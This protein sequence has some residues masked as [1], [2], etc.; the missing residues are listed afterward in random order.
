MVSSVDATRSLRSLSAT[1]QNRALLPVPITAAAQ[2][3]QY[4]L[5][6]WVNTKHSHYMSK[7]LSLM[8]MN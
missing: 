4:R 8:Y 7:D 3:A 2:N 5:I 6:N 1:I